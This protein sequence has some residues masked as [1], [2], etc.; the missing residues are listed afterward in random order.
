[1][2]AGAIVTDGARAAARSSHSERG[3]TRVQL[4]ARSSSEALRSL[5][6]QPASPHAVFPWAPG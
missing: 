6:R 3:V 2:L 1:M 4:R 5:R